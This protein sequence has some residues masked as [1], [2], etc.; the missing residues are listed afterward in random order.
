MAYKH[1]KDLTKL[2]DDEAPEARGPG[3]VV[4]D[5]EFRFD[6]GEMLTIKSRWIGCHSGGPGFY[7]ILKHLDDTEIARG[8]EFVP[9]LNQAIDQAR[10]Y[11]DGAKK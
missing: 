6:S 7:W 4:I 3:Q 8:T 5:T 10:T 11:T 9:I 1:H 2:T